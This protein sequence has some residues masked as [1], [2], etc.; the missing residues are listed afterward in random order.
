MN[1]EFEGSLTLESV[2]NHHTIL[3]TF[4]KVYNFFSSF[5]SF[6]I[7][8]PGIENSLL[9]KAIYQSGLHQ[10][11]RISRYALGDTLQ[12]VD[13]LWELARQ[14]QRASLKIHRHLGRASW[15]S[16]LGW[17]CYPQAEFLR[18]ALFCCKGLSTDWIRPTQIISDNLFYSK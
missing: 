6:V 18:E 10:R 7:I 14:V 12:A 17:S 16:W 2:P 9:C 5:T 11:N 1:L 4:L 13:L 15:N 3:A 8:S